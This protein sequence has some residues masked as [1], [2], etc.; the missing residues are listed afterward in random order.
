MASRISS[1]LAATGSIRFWLFDAR[2]SFVLNEMK[3]RS[4]SA[5]APVMS[6]SLWKSRPLDH[7]LSEGFVDVTDVFG[8]TKCKVIQNK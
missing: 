3:S 4:I 8:Q 2:A 6:P 5:K 1:V 7:C